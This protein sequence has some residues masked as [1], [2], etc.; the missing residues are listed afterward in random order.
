MTFGISLPCLSF[1]SLYTHLHRPG[2]LWDSSDWRQFITAWIYIWEKVD[3]HTLPYI[4]QGAKAIYI[5]IKS[6]QLLFVLCF[7]KVNNSNT[8]EKKQESQEMH[9]GGTLVLAN[10]AFACNYIYNLKINEN[11]EYFVFLFR[12]V[13]ANIKKCFILKQHCK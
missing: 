13:T 8:D 12:W 5:F 2:S 3:I 7:N 6:L 4:L 9:Y 1:K 10:T 11:N